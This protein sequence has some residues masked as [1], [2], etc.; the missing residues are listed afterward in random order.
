MNFIDA[1]KE[2]KKGERV[3]HS[4]M[5]NSTYLVLR[6]NE[7]LYQ[8]CDRHNTISLRLAVHANTVLRDDWEVVKEEPKVFI[9]DEVD[10]YYR[11]R[12]GDIVYV[13]HIDKKFNAFGEEKFLEH[14]PVDGIRD[15]PLDKE[16]FFT[17]TY[18]ITGR[19]K[20]FSASSGD[21][22]EKIGKELP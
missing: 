14:Y 21:I 17:E 4:N 6:E 2:L 11:C 8:E 22:V 20:G 3:R 12:N 18:K 9:V 5:A 7:V 13:Y 15:Y 16:L 1:M 19:V 10:C